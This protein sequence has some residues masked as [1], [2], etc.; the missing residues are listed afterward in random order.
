MIIDIILGVALVT[1]GGMAQHYREQR[2][3]L[4]AAWVHEHPEDFPGL[5]EVDDES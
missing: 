5:D 3:N 2:N 4:A 1:V